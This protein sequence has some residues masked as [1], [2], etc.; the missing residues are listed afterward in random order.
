M[1]VPMHIRGLCVTRRGGCSFPFSR[2]VKCRCGQS[3]W[4]FCSARRPSP[5]THRCHI[6][7]VDTWPLPACS[8]LA[9][10]F[11][12]P[13]RKDINRTCSASVHRR[14]RA[15]GYC[16]ECQQGVG[17]HRKAKAGVC[18]VTQSDKRRNRVFFWCS[19]RGR[20]DSA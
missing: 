10:D 20:V 9:V 5:F 6:R 2:P 13:R 3:G 4:A 7:Q 1:T 18:L 12:I 17:V 11:E 15:T 8:A 16:G 19:V 14:A